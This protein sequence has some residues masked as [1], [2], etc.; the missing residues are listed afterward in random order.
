MEV[1]RLSSR[2]KFSATHPNVY[3]AA[4]S[5]ALLVPGSLI[6]IAGVA[7]LL[8]F[9]NDGE[10]QLDLL[11]FGIAIIYATLFVVAYVWR[12]RED[13]ESRVGADPA[14]VNTRD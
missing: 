2:P 9:G 11:V 10:A 5:A 7:V 4:V 6:L 13:D 12:D 3:R 14:K 1:D 8:A